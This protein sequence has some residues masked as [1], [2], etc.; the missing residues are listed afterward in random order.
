[1]KISKMIKISVPETGKSIV[2]VRYGKSGKAVQISFPVNFLTSE[3]ASFTGAL[4]AEGYISPDFNVGFW[5]VD[6]E[7]LDKFI[8]MSKRLFSD[9]IRVNYK[10]YGC[11]FPAI[12]GQILIIGL[13]FKVGDKT[14]KNVGMPS[15]Y[16][17]SKNKKIL[18]N[19]LGWL[20]TG[21][22]WASLHVDKMKHLH[23]VIGI[24]FGSS[25]EDKIPKLIKDV[26]FILDFLKIR[27]RKPRQQISM[28]K[29]GKLKYY[30]SLI[31]AGKNNITEFKDRIGFIDKKKQ[32]I[33]NDILKSYIRP[34]F[35]PNESLNN[36]MKAVEYLYSSDKDVN[37]HSISEITKLNEKWIETLLKRAKD[38]KKITVIGGGE[39]INGRLGGKSPYIYKPLKCI[40]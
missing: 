40:K 4:L 18:K 34:Q 29:S 5:N 6:R 7:V 17:N 19:L 2:K 33:V 21:D 24:A 32:N 12:I 13:D 9:G 14:K 22:G 11:F 37:K 25:K 23:R 8:E 36:V 16:L 28:Q 26:D 10:I 15:I 35:S 39:R 27:H 3:W 31:I 1:M 30:W 38:M 20:F